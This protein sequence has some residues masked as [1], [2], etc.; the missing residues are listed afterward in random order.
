MYKGG[1]DVFVT[2]M[3]GSLTN[4]INSTYLGGAGD[5]E[6]YGIDL[7]FS[8]NV[9]IAGY[10][11]STGYPRSP[12]DNVFATGY[13][14][15]YMGAKDA[16]V[17]RLGNSLTNAPNSTLLGYTNDDVAYSVLVAGDSGNTNV[18]VTGY[19]LSSNFPITRNVYDSSHNGNSDVFLSYFQYSLTNLTASTYIGGSGN[20][21]GYA[22]ALDAETNRVFVAG[23]S[24]SANFPVTAGAYQQFPSGGYNGFVSKLSADMLYGSLKWQYKPVDAGAL[25][26]PAFGS[27]GTIYVADNYGNLYAVSPEGQL[28]WENYAGNENA[29]RGAPAVSTNG[30]IYF[31]THD[32]ETENNL[33]SVGP[34]CSTNW[35][36]SLGRFVK[37]SPA[38][39]TDGMIYG[40]CFEESYLYA[41]NPNG[42]TNWKTDVIGNM[43]GSPVIGTNGQIYVSLSASYLYSMSPSGTTNWRA[44][45]GSGT[46]AYSSPAIG[47]NGTI[48]VGSGGKLW[49][50]ANNGTINWSNQLAGAGDIWSA[51]VI[52]TNGVIYI[53]N[54][55]D[56]FVAI[57]PNGTTKWTRDL[58]GDVKSSAAIGEDGTIFVGSDG[59]W[60]YAFNPDGTTNWT[61]NAGDVFNY[62]APLLA[63]D[64]TVF[65]SAGDN[66]F[67][68]F[69]NEKSAD[70]DWPMFQHDLLRT[71][72]SALGPPD[73]VPPTGVSA[74]VT[75]SD[76]VRV[77]WN[78]VS[79]ATLY[80]VWRC[81]SNDVA[82]AS[83]L[84]ETT[85]T[86]YDD[87]FI[88]TGY[89]YY[90]WVKS[91][92]P[93]KTGSLSSP[94][95]LGGVPTLPPEGVTATDGF[96]TNL[97]SS[98]VHVTWTNCSG[99]TGY[100]ILRS[101]GNTN[102]PA[103]IGISLTT[104]YD[105]TTMP[106]GLT[107]YYWVKSHNLTTTSDVSSVDS[108]G[109]PPS[110]PTGVAASQGTLTN[111][112]KATW[113]S[114]PGATV[115]ELFRG[116]T[117]VASASTLLIATGSTIY[118]DT[119]TIACLEYTYWTKATNVY[120]I[121]GYSTSATGHRALAPPITV[122]ATDGTFTNKVK[123]S[124]ST[125]K[126]LDQVSAYRV[127]RSTVNDPLTASQ[128]VELEFAVG[129]PITNYA[130]QEI[131]RGATYYYWLKSKNV[132]GIST[133]SPSDV[134][135][136]AP[137]SPLSISASDGTYTG[138][139]AITWNSAFGATGY[140]I[141]RLETAD[142]S[143]AA[144]IGTVKGTN[145][146]DT[147]VSPGTRYFYWVKSTNTFGKSAL[148]GFDSGWR[149]LSP[150]TAV[151]A[152]DGA[153]TGH[154]WVT[155]SASEN[156]TA[157]E[158]WRGTNSDS[159]SASELENYI[160]T[161]SYDDLSSI[162]G[163]VYYF[164]VK[165]KNVSFTSGFSDYDIGY[166]ALGSV[167]IG[168]SDFIFLP[169][170]P[171]AGE[172]PDAVSFHVT[173]YG[174]ND[175]T[176]PNAWV[177]SDF[178]L[179]LN[180][181]FGDSDDVWIGRST[182]SAELT[183]GSSTVITLSQSDRSGVTIPS[184]ATGT[185]YVFVYVQHTLPS[186]WND[187]KTT[188]NSA[189]RAGGAIQIRE[190]ASVPYII[191]DFTGDG[192][193]DLAVYHD[194]TGLWFVRE[195]DGTLILYGEAWGGAGFMPVVGDFDGD[196]KVDLAVYKEETGQWYIR[197]VAGS[198]ILWNASW[199]GAGFVPVWGDYD[200]DR[201]VDLAVYHEESGTWYIRSVAGS[202]IAWGDIWGGTGYT[203]VCGDYNREGRTDLAV[204][205]AGD[206]NWFIRNLSGSV[207]LYGTAW[208]GE[209]QFAPVPGDYDG[210]GIS[211]LAVYHETSGYWFIMSTAGVQIAWGTYW[212][213]SGFVPVPGDYDGDGKTDLAV[214]HTEMGLWFIRGVDG[215]SIIYGENW[216]GA[217]FTP[218]SLAQ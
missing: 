154:L 14:N 85:R 31:C 136:T 138:K 94:G 164:W 211:D 153:S 149:D 76:R 93:V 19:T 56:N 81:S 108:G 145:Y 54:N 130:D 12:K 96:P 168:V 8:T 198:L 38:I 218:V 105:D 121:S 172:N 192:K 184:S 47:S 48:Y 24:A 209:E 113:N 62:S 60:L 124:W 82:S 161:N 73:P 4:L 157:Y 215:T 5:E 181:V 176:L 112:L 88:T 142:S 166:R 44:D 95:A 87:G 55:S 40:G 41:I 83:R 99:A 213:G 92:N 189:Q 39:G 144:V 162:P 194:A 151:D 2:R 17:T 140:Q 156:A 23:A 9:Y 118:N 1:K 64:G 197:S 160:T 10:T 146:D 217:G 58:G 143:Y 79:D 139:V 36:C 42:T 177:A 29:I 158:L 91:K 167:D 90:Y 202:V 150:P 147:A 182:A 187:P 119:N 22:L 196:G 51:P 107:N 70:G 15:C 32:V 13:T 35:G 3:A 174:N 66:L 141:Y 49:S 206:Y 102:S 116:T 26:P 137:R 110:P 37:Q 84:G 201:K 59:G 89:N 205:A 45:F 65:F 203:P 25:S 171:A 71:R 68:I 21:A 180:A 132:Y 200:G 100:R 16:F 74:S 148:S 185:Y 169:S 104:N 63:S 11:E 43:Y 115:Y 57:N 155:W 109:I 34:D 173:N 207:I 72:N 127:F 67:A 193:A 165:A 125:N 77:S 128:R 78:S 152:S 210:D 75:N 199:G 208:G 86:W 97:W 159:S 126:V 117:T 190:T 195:V 61:F 98:Q 214:Y 111:A 212:G 179:S 186:T 103:F 129:S 7:D 216:G 80:E 134:G 191:N 163:Q 101:T 28:I 53:G 135:G 20:D 33:F 183:V 106:P 123:V 69:G 131:D 50:V 170:A 133:F 27:D 175:M 30:T 122:N 204:Y 188:N 52:D 6:A 178:Y 114:S 18:Y 46:E 120:G